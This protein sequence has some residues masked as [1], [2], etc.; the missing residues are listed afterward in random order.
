MCVLFKH[1]V[2]YKTSELQY[3]FIFTLL[4]YSC[5]VSSVTISKVKEKKNSVMYCIPTCKNKRNGSC[6]FELL[7]R[8]LTNKC[9]AFDNNHSK[10]LNLVIQ[11]IVILYVYNLFL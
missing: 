3:K 6:R 11:T 8:L 2:N 10:S 1:K 5:I 7:S 4:S 9:G